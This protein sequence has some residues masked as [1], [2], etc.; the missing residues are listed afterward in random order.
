M[1]SPKKNVKREYYIFNKCR[2]SSISC[3][4]V[5]DKI[6]NHNHGIKTK[7]GL[8]CLKITQVIYNI[9]NFETILLFYSNTF[10]LQLIL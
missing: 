6:E 5:E 4:S 9:L 8:Q 1:S 3:V 2:N 7:S 10:N